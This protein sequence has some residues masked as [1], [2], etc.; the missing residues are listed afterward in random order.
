MKNLE[1]MNNASLFVALES[2]CFALARNHTKG[3][4]KR[5][6]AIEKEMAKRLGVPWEELDGIL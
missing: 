2:A 4:E 5:L 1:E 6:L 3:N